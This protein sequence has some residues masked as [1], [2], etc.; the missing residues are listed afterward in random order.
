MY[1]GTTP[2]HI[3]EIPFDTSLV[4][5]CKITYSQDSRIILE[6]KTDECTFD[7]KFIKTTL[8]QAETFLFDYKRTVQIQLRVLTQYG[9]A[10]AAD[11]ENIPAHICL[12][13]EVL[14]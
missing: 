4:K 14:E 13:D 8:S 11:I 3:F 1:I 9:E 10:L 7:G 6:K 12:D 2:T 5:V